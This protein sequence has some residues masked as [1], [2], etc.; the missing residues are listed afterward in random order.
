MF[1]K[2]TAPDI[3]SLEKRSGGAGECVAGVAFLDAA[4]LWRGNKGVV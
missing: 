2:T 4:V 1:S 3:S